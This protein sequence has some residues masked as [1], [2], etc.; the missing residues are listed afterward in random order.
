M[1][2]NICD[3]IRGGVEKKIN[4]LDNIYYDIWYIALWFDTEEFPCREA[5]GCV[6]SEI[7][8]KINEAN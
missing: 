2:I 3:Q 4:I 8:E 5:M 1:K 7:S 6:L